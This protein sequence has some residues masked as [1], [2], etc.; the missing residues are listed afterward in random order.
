M[1]R[2]FASQSYICLT[3]NEIAVGGDI[4]IAVTFVLRFFGVKKLT[5]K[6]HFMRLIDI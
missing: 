3:A 6:N 5:D 1:D 4:A 2:N